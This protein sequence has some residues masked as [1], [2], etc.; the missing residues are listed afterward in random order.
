[1]YEAK[2]RNKNKKMKFARALKSYAEGR[3]ELANFLTGAKIHKPLLP[4]AYEEFFKAKEVL[5]KSDVSVWDTIIDVYSERLIDINEKYK[6]IVL[7]VNAV[8]SKRLK[9]VDN[10][11]RGQYVI[12]TTRNGISKA[13]FTTLKVQVF[14]DK[15]GVKSMCYIDNL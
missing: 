3:L 11:F 15:D 2:E 6:I 8:A 12:I 10:L 1:M 4:L 5:N 14:Y 9:I 7:F 13:T